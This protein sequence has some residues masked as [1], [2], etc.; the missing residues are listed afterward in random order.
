MFEMRAKLGIRSEAFVRKFAEHRK[1]P[2]GVAIDAIIMAV[3][4]Q[5]GLKIQERVDAEDMQ[6]SKRRI[7]AARGHVAPVDV[8]G[9]Y[10]EPF[11]TPIEDS[12]GPP[13]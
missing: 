8:D 5:G 2:L 7:E 1:V 3:I 6:A 12:D 13:I 4:D 9:G 10:S 11:G